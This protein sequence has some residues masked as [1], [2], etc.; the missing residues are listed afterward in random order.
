MGD[1]REMDGVGGIFSLWGWPFLV[2]VLCFLVK[3][4]NKVG[5]HRLLVSCTGLNRRA[6]RGSRVSVTF[7][8][9]SSLSLP[10][11]F[12]TIVSEIGPPRVDLFLHGSGFL[13]VCERE[14]CCTLFFGSFLGLWR[15][16]ACHI[17]KH[18]GQICFSVF[19][20]LV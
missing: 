4:A 20:F 16:P 2:S 7:S 3:I 13:C 19:A 1:T 11:A 8:D 9:C 17:G 12:V 14:R 10:L 6:G 5:C 18:G 15:G